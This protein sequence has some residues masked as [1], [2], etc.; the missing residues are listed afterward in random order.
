MYHEVYGYAPRAAAPPAHSYWG[1]NTTQSISPSKI[2]VVILKMNLGGFKAFTT[3]L[4]SPGNRECFW[5]GRE[6]HQSP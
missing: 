3:T 6:R 5:F 2:W 1:N 4:P